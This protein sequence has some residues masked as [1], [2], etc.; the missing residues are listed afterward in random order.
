[1]CPACPVSRK[2]KAAN[3]LRAEKHVHSEHNII[4]TEVS[5]GVTHNWE[6][7][8]KLLSK[9]SCKI[10]VVHKVLHYPSATCIPIEGVQR[11]KCYLHV[12]HDRS[13]S[14]SAIFVQYFCMFS[15]NICTI[16]RA[17]HKLALSC[18]DAVSRSRG[19]GLS[20]AFGP[21]ITASSCSTCHTPCQRHALTK[22][23]T[24][25]QIQHAGVDG[26]TG[27]PRCLQLSLV[28]SVLHIMCN[29]SN[30]T[31]MCMH[32][33]GGSSRSCSSSSDPLGTLHACTN[34]LHQ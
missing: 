8:G 12:S 21:V 11:S 29:C 30:C 19:V 9:M 20:P 26:C 10:V 33:Q 22:P 34:N 15:N 28:A 27:L 32:D 14:T 2:L 31:D 24:A 4:N 16:L 25:K 18:N 13:Q 23:M 7:R 17:S 5:H 1:M 3:E 6:R